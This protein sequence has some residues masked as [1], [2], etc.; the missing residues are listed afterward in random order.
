[1]APGRENGEVSY[2][3]EEVLD[4]VTAPPR[5]TMLFCTA[6]FSQENSYIKE[7]KVKFTR[8]SSILQN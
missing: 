6:D 4:R 1:M 2:G 3:E 5:R 8:P 7:M